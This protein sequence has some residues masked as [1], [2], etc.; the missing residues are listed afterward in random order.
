M[1]LEEWRTLP[2]YFVNAYE[3]GGIFIHNVFVYLT[4]A[5]PFLCDCI[6]EWGTH[7]WKITV[8]FTEEHINTRDNC[9]LEGQGRQVGT[10]CLPRIVNLHCHRRL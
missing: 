3:N 4:V 9:C 10:I 5:A 6:S 1:C 8:C 7:V 2:A